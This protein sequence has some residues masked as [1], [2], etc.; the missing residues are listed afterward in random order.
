VGFFNRVAWR[1]AV[2]QEVD[3]ELAFHLEMRTR[4]YIERGMDPA[5][6]RRQAEKRLGDVR[7]M[8]TALAAL[9]RGRNSQ[10]Q[11]TE[12]FSEL[13][14]D[15]GF[16]WRQLVKNPGFT[17]VAVLTLALGIGGTTAIFSAVYAVVLQP[18]PLADPARLVVVAETYQGSP[19]GVSAGNYTDAAAGVPAFEGLTAL[20]FSSFNLSEGTT[21]ER[22]IG[23]RITANY[24]DVM[25]ARPLLGRTFTPSEDQPGN[26]RVV[27]LSHRLWTRRFGANP[28]VI[29]SAIRMNGISYS[30]IAVMPQSFDLSTDS[31]ELW[32]PIAFTPAQKVLHDEHY[33]TVYG[34]LRPGATRTQAEQQLEA[35]AVRLRREF[36]HHASEL[37]YSTAPFMERFVGDYD[38]RLFVLLAAVGVVLLIACGN[39]ANLLLARGAAR[40]REIALRSALGAGRGRIVRQLLTES[41]VLAL[42][43]AMAGLLLARWF[44]DAVV[45]LSPQGVPRLEQARIDPLALGVAVLL[46][47][48]SSVLCGLAP[49]LRLART[50]IQG[51]LRDGGRGSTAGSFRDR[52]RGGLIAGEVALSLLLLF[53]AGLLIRSSIAL[54]RVNPGFDP[55]GVISA[56][57]ALPQASY[58]DP[59]RILDTFEHMASETASIPGVSHAALT[60][61]AAMGAGGGTNGLLPDDG[62]PFDMKN[63]VPGG[64][65]MITPGFFQTMRIPI[66]KGRAFDTTDRRDGQRVMII[67]ETL[68]ARMFPGQD[69]LGRRIGC[70]EQTPDQQPVWKVVVGVAGDVRSIGPATPPQPE[71][72]LPLTQAPDDSWNWT[73]RMMYVVARTDGDASALA[74]PLR[75]MVARIDPELPLYDVRL[76]D[77]RLAG[78]LET[79]RFNTLLLSLLGGIGLLLAA[80]GNYGVIAY[81]V[82]QRTQEIGVRIALGASSASVV[83]LILAQAMRPVAA[84]AAIGTIAALAASRVIASQ[85]FNV[86]RTDPLTIGAVVAALVGV[87]LVASAVPA[88]RAAAVDPTRALQSE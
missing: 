5:A 59:S 60:S 44:V 6:A 76:M 41:V 74:A 18:L 49:A 57:V 11:R 54:Q 61:F 13:R 28:S 3:D 23:G 37:R 29:G 55:H 19:G 33:L 40:A 48:F 4:E 21:P 67:S 83:R 77:Q 36:P 8:R 71:F 58:G 69:P 56:R 87:A 43:A 53:G 81:F 42:T 2:D 32:T 22:I 27:I 15:I 14:Q 31:E 39:V 64:L 24:F 26:D 10:M 30:V 78:A 88:R 65:R 86:S 80:S 17:A 72:Y 47:L 38:T 51:G 84:G 9:G 34:R 46:A 12:Y 20:R 7:E 66:V 16:A 70:C 63:L 25:G 73:Q 45:A 85:L 68:A 82:S 50:D 52:L 75:T 35:V 62:R 79:T 1:P